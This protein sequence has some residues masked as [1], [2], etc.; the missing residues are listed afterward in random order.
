MAILLLSQ[1]I[2]S[3]L[4]IESIDT[5]DRH[6]IG[7]NVVERFRAIWD[8]YEKLSKLSWP[9]IYKSFSKADAPSLVILDMNFITVPEST[10]K[11]A[12]NVFTITLKKSGAK[13]AP[14]WSCLEKRLHFSKVEPFFP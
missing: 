10:Q 6:V 9:A 4:E 7:E 2:T 11:M 1:G 3:R 8:R 13:M 5:Q 12:L 14:L